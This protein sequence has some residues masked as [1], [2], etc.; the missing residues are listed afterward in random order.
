MARDFYVNG[1]TMCSVKG[2]SSSSISAISQLG[3]CTDQ[4]SI[5]FQNNHQGIQVNTFWDIPPEYQYALGEAT[6]TTNLVHFD[7]T[8]YKECLRLSAGGAPAVGQMPRAGSRMGGGVARFA[9]GW[10]F[11]SLNFS[12]PVGGQPLNFYNCMLTGP[13]A[14]FPLGNERSIVQLQWKACLYQADPWGGGTG[15]LGAVL[16]TFSNDS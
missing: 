7:Y 1:E 3:L 14:S 13:A 2:N 15:A 5:S 9:P 6:I 4:V 16:Y 8:V 11:I 12:A 10:N